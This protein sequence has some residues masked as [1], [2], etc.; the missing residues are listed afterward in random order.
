MLSLDGNGKKDN[1]EDP[2]KQ[3]E[4]TESMA[5]AASNSLVDSDYWFLFTQ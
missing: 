3:E 2:R 5:H 1:R 4:N